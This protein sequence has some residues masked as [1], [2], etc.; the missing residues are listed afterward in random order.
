MENLLM[1]ELRNLNIVSPIDSHTGGVEVIGQDQHTRM[2]DLPFTKKIGATTYL[3][4]GGT[5]GDTSIVVNT[6]ITGLAAG[7]L[8]GLFDTTGTH[9]SFFQAV[10]T[11]TTTIQLDRPLDRDYPVTT[12]FV[13]GG[14]GNMNINGDPVT[15][16]R[17]QIYRVGPLGGDIEMDVTRIIGFMVGGTTN[18]AWDD[19]KF[20]PYGALT[21]G[22]QLRKLEADGN[23]LNYWNVKTNGQLSLLCY[24]GAFN[25][26]ANPA[27]NSSYW[28][29]NTF[30]GPSKHGVVVRLHQGEALEIL[31]QDDLTADTGFIMNIAAQGHLT[32]G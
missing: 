4:T 7:H 6:A 23:Y 25:R 30:G 20:G 22:I 31:I 11:P 18:P 24:D 14:N 12:T 10:G 2:L 29:R 13:N 16:T 21:Y 15:G 3:T 19:T 27:G 26:G 32:T 9:F 5:K 28:W 1:T 17:P 8:V